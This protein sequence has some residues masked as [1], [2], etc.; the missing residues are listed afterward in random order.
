MAATCAVRSCTLIAI[1]ACAET[2][3]CPPL[4]VSED[5][6]ALVRDTWSMTVPVIAAVVGATSPPARSCP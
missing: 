3:A 1:E 5:P 6:S 4:I 2:I